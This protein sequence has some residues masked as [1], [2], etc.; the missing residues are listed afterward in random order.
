[1]HYVNKNYDEGNVI[2]QAKTDIELTDNV[3]SIAK[4]VQKLEHKYYPIVIDKI[5]LNL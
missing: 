5:L 1:M 2:F 3:E 4:K